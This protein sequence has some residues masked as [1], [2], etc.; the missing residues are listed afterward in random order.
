MPCVFVWMCVRKPRVHT[1]CPSQLLSLLFSKAAWPTEAGAGWTSWP[2]PRPP[3][4]LPGPSE[5]ASQTLCA[6]L[7]GQDSEPRYRLATGVLQREPEFIV[8]QA[9]LLTLPLLLWFVS[10]VYVAIVYISF[11]IVPKSLLHP[12]PTL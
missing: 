9:A 10:P 7:P 12:A 8:H 4:H 2:E 3:P 5:S 1:Q 11:Q 6:S